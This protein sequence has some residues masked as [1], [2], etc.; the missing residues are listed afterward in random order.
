MRGRRS[1]GRVCW[2]WGGLG[3]KGYETAAPF[4]ESGGGFRGIPVKGRAG[5]RALGASCGRTGDH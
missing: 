4:V 5:V 2:T 3:G 1:E